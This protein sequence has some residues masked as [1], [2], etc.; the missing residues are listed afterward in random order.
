[1][2]RYVDEIVRYLNEGREDKIIMLLDIGQSQ[3][4]ISY[5]VVEIVKK[6]SSKNILLF[7]GLLRKYEDCD[8]LKNP[9]HHLTD[10]ST[11]G[12]KFFASKIFGLQKVKINIENAMHLISNHMNDELKFYFDKRIQSLMKMKN[13][14]HI[15]LKLFICAV[16]CKNFDAIDYLM[17]MLEKFGKTIDPTRVQLYSLRDPKPLM[18]STILKRPDCI[19]YSVMK[20]FARNLY[21]PNFIFK[22]YKLQSDGFFQL[23][24][25]NGSEEQLKYLDVATKMCPEFRL[26]LQSILPNVLIDILINYF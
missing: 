7:I 14:N 5:E 11:E 3:S 1:M 18:L 19:S 16:D 20:Y 12:L 2:A 21:H 26:T 13:G 6:L 4:D 22:M 9:F 25:E 8:I 17:S 15:C 23:I 24:T 10:F